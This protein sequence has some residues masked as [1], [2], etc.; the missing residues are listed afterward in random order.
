MLCRVGRTVLTLVGMVG[1]GT[2]YA[3]AE[4]L[5]GGY[6]WWFHLGGLVVTAGLVVWTLRRRRACSRDGAKAAGWNT[7][8]TNGDDPSG[9]ERCGDRRG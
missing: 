8:R 2:A 3:W 1:A 5:Y 4:N 7:G 6:A 9:V